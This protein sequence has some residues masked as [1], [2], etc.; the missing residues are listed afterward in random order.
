MEEMSKEDRWREKSVTH[1]EGPHTHILLKRRVIL[2]LLYC[3]YHHLDILCHWHKGHGRYRASVSSLVTITMTLREVA[4]NVGG[5]LKCELIFTFHAFVISK[6]VNTY[7]LKAH[8]LKPISH[9]LTS[10]PLNLFINVF[11]LCMSVVI[12]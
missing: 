5:T 8:C 2:M 7:K 11:V 10:F 3:M 9:A 12:K 1:S 6:L 4:N